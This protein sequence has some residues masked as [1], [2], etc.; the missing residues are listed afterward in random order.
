MCMYIK[1]WCLYLLCHIDKKKITKSE[2]DEALQ[3]GN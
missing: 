3:K 1:Y 2:R